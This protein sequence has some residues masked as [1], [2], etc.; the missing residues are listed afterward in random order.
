M[1][2]PHKATGYKEIINNNNDVDASISVYH[3]G[4]E[5]SITIITIIIV[6]ILTVD[7]YIVGYFSSSLQLFHQE[8]FFSI[9]RISSTSS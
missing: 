6:I 4:E 7:D 3:V 8:G 9:D 1:R 5:E 2:K